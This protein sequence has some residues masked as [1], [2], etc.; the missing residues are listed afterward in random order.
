MI[1]VIGSLKA[2]QV[3]GLFV[4]GKHKFANYNLNDQITMNGRCYD[5]CDID[6]EAIWIADQ[7]G[8]VYEFTPGTED[9]HVR[10]RI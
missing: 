2:N 1:S 8:E 4:N 7:D 9:N 6:D 3:K 5:I 10:G